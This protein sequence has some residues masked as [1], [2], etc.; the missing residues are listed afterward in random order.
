M[1]GV[2]M[3]EGDLIALRILLTG[4]A[5][6]LERGYTIT[7]KAEAVARLRRAADDLHT[8]ES[9]ARRDVLRARLA[10]IRERTTNKEQP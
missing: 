7:D 4:A 8:P 6:D 9:R 1:A 10:A 3:D 2:W 5:D